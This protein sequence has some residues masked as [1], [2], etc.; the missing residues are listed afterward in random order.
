M[1]A[2]LATT[3]ADAHKPNE[4]FAGLL[5]RSAVLLDGAGLS[6]TATLCRHG[7]AWYTNTLG[8]NILSLLGS[9]ERTTLTEILE[10][11][12]AQTAESHRDTCDLQDPGTPSATVI[13]VRAAE[14]ALDYLVLAD[15]VLIINRADGSLAVTTDDRE[16]RIGHQYRAEMD[17]LDNGTPEHDHARRQY[18]QKMRAHRNKPDGFWVA[19]ADPG[20]AREALTGQLPISQ[21]RSVAMLSDGASRL[22]DRFGLATWDDAMKILSKEGPDELIRLVRDAELSDEAGSRWP[23]GK[24]YDDATAVLFEP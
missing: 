23:R 11:A 21:I 19:A 6:G 22:V 1:K 12:I 2:T 20:A 8:V 7:V 10:K 5:P 15:S 9:G 13:I 4:D 17:R 18:V 24:T 16:A 3:P 14:G